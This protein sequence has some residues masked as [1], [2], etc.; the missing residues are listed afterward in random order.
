MRIFENRIWG[1]FR[2]S[3]FHDFTRMIEPPSWGVRWPAKGHRQVP[4]DWLHWERNGTEW[5]LVRRNSL[6]VCFELKM[7]QKIGKKFENVLTRPE[8]S[9]NGRAISG[10]FSTVVLRLFLA[11]FGFS[12]PEGARAR[13][14]RTHMS[15]NGRQCRP[16]PGPC[17]KWSKWRFFFPEIISPQTLTKKTEKQNYNPIFP[18]RKRAPPKRFWTIFTNFAKN[19]LR[20]VFPDRF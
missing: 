7:G 19:W 15:Q 4:S 11:H 9:E 12:S 8:G 14:T 10:Q 20:N 6:F 1:L 16:P 5:K 3:R 2:E 13:A 18:T 17:L